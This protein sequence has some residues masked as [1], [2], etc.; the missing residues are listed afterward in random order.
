MTTSRLAAVLR[1]RALLGVWCDT[2][3]GD[4]ARVSR[5][6]YRGSACS[7][8][9]FTAVIGNAEPQRAA[10]RDARPCAPLFGCRPPDHD[11]LYAEE[12]KAFEATGG[13]D[14][15]VAVSRSDGDKSY[16]L[17]VLRAKRMHVGRDRDHLCLRRQRKD[18]AGREAPHR[19]TFIARRLSMTSR[20]RRG[21]SRLAGRTA[22]RST[23]G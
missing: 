7:L 2:A 8:T 19:S 15:R 4:S 13:T 14:L 1:D 16:V 17:E 11:F 21:W 3:D 12:L 22:T 23:W 10:R 5:G 9:E 6:C 18:G 20:R